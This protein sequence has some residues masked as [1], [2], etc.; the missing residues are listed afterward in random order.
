MTRPARARSFSRPCHFF[1]TSFPDCAGRQASATCEGEGEG[2]A[3]R[4]L[5]CTLCQCGETGSRAHLRLEDEIGR[6]MMGR[7]EEDAALHLAVES[8]EREAAAD[9]FSVDAA[10]APRSA[11]SPVGRAR[12]AR[13]LR[14]AHAPWPREREWGCA[15]AWQGR[16]LSSTQFRK[17]DR[18]VS[19]RG[20]QRLLPGLRGEPTSV[21]S[22]HCSAMYSMSCIH[23][24]RLLAV[25]N[26]VA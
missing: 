19:R 10:A 20:A 22:H 21:P 5:C 3:P 4:S 9:L 1:R 26:R 8:E 18:E 6:L 13:V 2:I 23:P 24:C 25:G 7:W 17:V 11:R 12:V 14:R 15:A 16:R